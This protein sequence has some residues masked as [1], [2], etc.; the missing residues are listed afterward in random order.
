MVERFREIISRYVPE[1]AA[2]YCVQRWKEDP[3]SFRVTRQR[4]SKL[5]DYRFNRET[6]NH[7]ITVNGNLNPYA[8]LITFL[9]EVAHLKHYI[10]YKNNGTPHGCPWKN[11]FR[12]LMKPVLTDTIFPRELL[13]HLEKHMKNP[14]ASSQSD[15]VLSK[16]LRQYDLQKHVP[17]VYLE[18][19]SDGDSFIFKGR[20]FTKIRRRRTRS[21]CVDDSTGRKY[22]IPEM[23]K[24]ERSEK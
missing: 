17:D 19:L 10:K 6:G 1:N 11:I 24:V 5:G 18:D 7:E 2:G 4:K 15:S 8:F 20:P 9:H 16:S 13:N 23:T 14:K 3:F 12:E 22:L 21:L